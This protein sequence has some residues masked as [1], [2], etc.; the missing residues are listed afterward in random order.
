MAI[1]L[2]GRRQR[3][4]CEAADHKGAGGPAE[5]LAQILQLEPPNM[6]TPHKAHINRWLRPILQVF[7]TPADPTGHKIP[8]RLEEAIEASVVVL[9]VFAWI[10][11]MTLLP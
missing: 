3:R 9:A 7:A 1:R 5:L 4:R 11:A 2:L 10:A 8:K 6:K